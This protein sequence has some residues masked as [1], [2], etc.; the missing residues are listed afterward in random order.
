MWDD[1][2]PTALDTLDLAGFAEAALKFRSDTKEL[3]SAGPNE[4]DAV[5]E[6]VVS[7]L[8]DSKQEDEEVHTPLQSSL[9]ANI[10]T[11]TAATIVSDYP[12]QA[13]STAIASS[14]LEQSL[15]P[16]LNFGISS[17]FDIFTTNA[18]SIEPVEW[19]YRDPQNQVQGPFSQ[20]T[21]KVWNDDGY[22]TLDLPIKMGRWQQF[23]LFKYVFPNPSS[24]FIEI[25][26]EPIQLSFP[27][28]QTSS[29]ISQSVKP[30]EAIPSNLAV[31]F[32]ESIRTND[33]SLP[34]ASQVV[35]ATSKQVPTGVSTDSSVQH[36]SEKSDFAKKLLGIGRKKD[37][38]A[39][40]PQ[41]SKVEVDATKAV[42]VESK[43]IVETSVNKPSKVSILSPL[44]CKQFLL[45]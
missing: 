29:T 32:G 27:F 16:Q 24:A 33:I 11:Q 44:F 21:M 18:P 17:S 3:K 41:E 34:Q 6:D 26:S 39:T 20:E 10:L 9:S 22:F 43:S 19:Y 23:H 8:F 25:P 35:Q 37:E 2:V 30:S 4:S 5:N 36:N 15:F 1:D 13:A 31:D 7:S 40:V 38:S 42:P 45:F 12:P 14:S 28:G